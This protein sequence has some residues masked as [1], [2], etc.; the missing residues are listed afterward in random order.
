MLLSLAQ[1]FGYGNL[2]IF[3][4]ATLAFNSAYLTGTPPL[5]EAQPWVMFFSHAL[6]HIGPVHMLGNLLTLYLLWYLMP[7]IYVI[8]FV[9]VFFVGALGGALGF[10]WL[11]PPGSLMT[12][13][14]G[15]VAG[16]TAVW[17]LCEMFLAQKGYILS[18]RPKWTAVLVGLVTLGLLLR[19]DQQLGMAWQT[20]LGGALAGAGFGA[21][22]IMRAIWKG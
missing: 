3:C 16:L 15:A 6:L 22:L 7:W 19:L 17:G 2:R 14:S 1:T 8:D 12:G 13:A 21:G 5:Y 9:L 20:H 18:I 10:L 11:A 4:F